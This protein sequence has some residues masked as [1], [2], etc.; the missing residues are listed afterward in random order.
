MT[1]V[2][3]TLST[4]LYGVWLALGLVWRAWKPPG[5]GTYLAPG[6]APRGGSWRADSE[7]HAE[8]PGVGAISDVSYLAWGAVTGIV[9]WPASLRRR[10]RR[11]SGHYLLVGSQAA[12]SGQRLGRPRPPAAAGE[13]R[14][15]YK[16][17]SASPDRRSIVRFILFK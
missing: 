12:V 6:N 15:R 8:A 11:R 16:Y 7:G 3:S 1:V 10:G 5:N 17:G 13:R 14:R 2:F 4:E 9:G